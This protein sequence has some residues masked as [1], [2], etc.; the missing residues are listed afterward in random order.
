MILRD[1]RGRRYLEKFRL[2]G[3]YYDKI[4]DLYCEPADKIIYR[5]YSY[6]NKCFNCRY[7]HSLTSSTDFCTLSGFTAKYYDFP[8]KSFRPVKYSWFFKE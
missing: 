1:S 8:C 3:K 7:F 2:D 5:Q 4:I 6:F